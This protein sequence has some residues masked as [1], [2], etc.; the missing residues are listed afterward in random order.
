MASKRYAEVNQE[1][2]VACGTCAFICPMEA[3]D[4]PDGCWAEI[5]PAVCVG[6][7]ACAKACPAGCIDLVE[8]A[9]GR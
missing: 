9:G 8:R 1:V 3:A 2:C 5:D 6:C 7:G 4:I